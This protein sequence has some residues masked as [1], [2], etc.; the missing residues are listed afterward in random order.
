MRRAF[1]GWKVLKEPHSYTNILVTILSQVRIN[2]ERTV[3]Y[4]EN[5]QRKRA[6]SARISFIRTV[7]S[8]RE[9]EKVIEGTNNYGT[10]TV[11]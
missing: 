4:E 3:S 11:I 5:S 8:E 9:V 6:E 10:D 1:T 2:E 7:K